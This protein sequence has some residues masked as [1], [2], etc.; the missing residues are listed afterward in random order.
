MKA[1]GLSE[2][3]HPELFQDVGQSRRQLGREF[4]PL[5]RRRVDERQAVGMEEEARELGL[6]F[7]PAVARVPGQG[8]P[9]RSQ[10]DPDAVDARIRE[11]NGDL[12]RKYGVAYAEE[13]RRMILR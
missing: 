2:A 4:D 10:V 13:F 12:G 1:M 9:G 6:L 8:M 7:P 3:R 5:P 11:W